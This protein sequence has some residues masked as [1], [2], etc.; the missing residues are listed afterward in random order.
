MHTYTHIYISRSRARLAPL[1]AR[2]HILLRL[3]MRRLHKKGNTK[4]RRCI[5]TETEGRHGGLSAAGAPLPSVSGCVLKK[6]NRKEKGGD[7]GW[8]SMSP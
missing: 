1:E 5:R 8:W 3:G 2:R 6:K 4:K 7:R